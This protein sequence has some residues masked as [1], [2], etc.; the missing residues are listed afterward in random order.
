MSVRP[1]LK[2]PIAN[3][4]IFQIEPP[5]APTGGGWGCSLQPPLG[6]VARMGYVCA[7]HGLYMAVMMLYM[8][9]VWVYMD[10]M[11]TAYG[12]HGVSGF[13]CWLCV[14]RTDCVWTLYVYAC[15]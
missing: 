3:L 9:C 6:T 2:G 5:P 11:R 15:V 4:Q 13:V 7:I 12:L 8:C 1:I 14:V 10:C